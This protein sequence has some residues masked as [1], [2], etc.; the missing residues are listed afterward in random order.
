MIGR[1]AAA[2]AAGTFVTLALLFVMQT[3]INMQSS[4]SSDPATGIPVI[5][6]P[7]AKPPPPPPPQPRSIER[8]KLTKTLLPPARVIRTGGDAPTAVR[9][10]GRPDFAGRSLGTGSDPVRLPKYVDGALVALVRVEPTYPLRA[11]SLGLEGHVLVQFDVLPDGRVTNALVIESSD[12]RFEKEALK[13]ALRFKYKAHVIDGVPLLSTG[14]QNL[15]TFV[16]ED[17]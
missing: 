12:R 13:A 17:T 6:L 5:W 15:F 3:L 2:V 9:L 14:V 16:M 1:Y 4:E 8:H 11:R 7:Y 10:P